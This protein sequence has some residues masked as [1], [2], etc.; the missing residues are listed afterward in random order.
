MDFGDITGSSGFQIAYPLLNMLLAGSSPRGAAASQAL[1][2]GLGLSNKYAE[3]NKAEAQS[4]LLGKSLGD[5]LKS[6]TPV[7]STQS[8]ASMPVNPATASFEMPG[9][10]EQTIDDINPSQKLGDALAPVPLQKQTTVTQKPNFSP[11]VQQ[12]G[13]ALVNAR[14]P[15]LL[16]PMLTKEL[17]RDP[18]LTAVRPGGSLV[19]EQGNLKYQAPPPPVRPATLPRPVVSEYGTMI[20]VKDPTTGEITWPSAPTPALSAPA[21]QL[22]P[23]ESERKRAQTAV[24]NARIPLIGAQTGAANASASNSRAQAGAATE[25]ANR[26]RDLTNQL[27]NPKITEEKATTIYG[28]AIRDRQALANSGSGDPEDVQRLKDANALVD[29]SRARLAE[30]QRQKGAPPPAAPPPGKPIGRTKDGKTVYQ[31]ADGKKYVA[32]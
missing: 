20:P 2:L 31:G 3:Q 32:N 16:L 12:L 13:S 21:R 17:I 4:K 25:R 6:T 24:E 29:S 22:P 30:I 19:D 18:K 14:K 27:N 10:K 15:D 5:V 23:E 7:S 1:N 26:L 8:V 9:V 11:Q 28:T